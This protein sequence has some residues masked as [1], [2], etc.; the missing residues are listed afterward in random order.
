LI[1]FSS[2][3]VHEAQKKQT[4]RAR[5]KKRTRERAQIDLMINQGK[6][7]QK[8]FIVLLIKPIRE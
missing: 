1:P 5:E 3:Y 6:V 8:D 4:K 2:K 7:K